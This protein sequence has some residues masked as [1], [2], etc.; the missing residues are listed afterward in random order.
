V[1][2]RLNTAS[3]REGARRA[4]NGTRSGWSEDRTSSLKD[5]KGSRFASAAAKRVGGMFGLDDPLV[6]FAKYFLSSTHIQGLPHS[7]PSLSPSGHCQRLGTTSEM[8]Q[9]RVATPYSALVLCWLCSMVASHQ[10]GHG[11]RYSYRAD[12]GCVYSMVA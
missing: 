4:T 6:D 11:T 7:P 12:R 5:E 1:V 9:Y 10:A 2:A 8:M 3:R